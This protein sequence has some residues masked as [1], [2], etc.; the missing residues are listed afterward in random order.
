MPVACAAGGV[1]LMRLPSI[2]Y[3]RNEPINPGAD[4]PRPPTR[5]GDFARDV[6][7]PPV[8]RHSQRIASIEPV[9]A[10]RTP[11]KIIGVE[12]SVLGGAGSAIRHIRLQ[13]LRRRCAGAPGH[14]S[15]HVGE[16]FAPPATLLS[17]PNP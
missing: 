1:V 3:D 15:S 14:E 12:G 5:C 17:L 11:R 16:A 10:E 8:L 13:S 9:L 2:S 6:A 4:H 7:T